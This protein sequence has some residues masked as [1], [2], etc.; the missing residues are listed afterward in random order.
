MGKLSLRHPKR[1]QAER[2]REQ[3]GSL[4]ERSELEGSV[5]RG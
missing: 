1:K 5:I 4:E 3:V 2:S